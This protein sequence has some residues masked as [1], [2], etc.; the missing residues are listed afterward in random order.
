MPSSDP[1]VLRRAAQ[2]YRERHPEKVRDYLDSPAGKLVQLTGNW[3]YNG[4]VTDD[5]IS[6][7]ITYMA[8]THCM[9]C[10][11]ELTKDKVRT[12]TTKC[13]DHDHATGEVRAIVCH[14]CNVRRGA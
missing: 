11:R 10:D 9:D 12:S 13:L 8:H 14:A 1:E 3:R 5:W 7:Y 6:L 4:V 2:R